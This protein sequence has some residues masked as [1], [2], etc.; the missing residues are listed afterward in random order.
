MPMDFALEKDLESLYEQLQYVSSER[1]QDL[2]SRILNKIHRIEPE[3]VYRDTIE[4]V[5]HYRR[6]YWSVKTGN[7]W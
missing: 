1:E 2:E 3:W 5:R 4:F 6:S 7:L